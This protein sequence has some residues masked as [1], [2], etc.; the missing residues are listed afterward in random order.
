VLCL[1]SNCQKR[2]YFRLTDIRYWRGSIIKDYLSIIDS[3]DW[4]F[5]P[6][7]R[8]S[9]KTLYR[10]K[11]IYMG[12]HTLSLSSHVTSEL[13]NIVVCPHVD[14]PGL[15]LRM[16]SSDHQTQ[17]VSCGCGHQFVWPIDKPWL[18]TPWQGGAG[19]CHVVFL[20]VFSNSYT[21]I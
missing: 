11:S 4:F 14:T 20:L 6:V 1:S 18:N 15:Q 13:M 8:Y 12:Y 2:K 9:M 19:G 17:H 16:E 5:L 10:I 3:T 7:A 21:G